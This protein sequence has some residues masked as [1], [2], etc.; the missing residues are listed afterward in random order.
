MS[1]LSLES[2]QAE[3]DYYQEHSANMDELLDRVDS[4]LENCYLTEE[5]YNKVTKR[6]K[7]DILDVNKF[8]EVNNCKCVSD[9]RAFSSNNIPSPNGLLSNEIFGYTME[10]RSGIF[11][12][13]DL[14]GWFMDPSLYKTWR[15][16]RR[17]R[18]W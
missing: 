15:T 4:L 12:Y 11:G 16:D 1:L 13:I 8:V 17:R 3:I 14:H 9:P 6:I 2:I 18:K 5:E 10:E 7:F